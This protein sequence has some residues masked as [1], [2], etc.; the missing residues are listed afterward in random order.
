V[1]NLDAAHATLSDSGVNF[2]SPP[3]PIGLLKACVA[4]DPEG[5]WLEFVELLN[6]RS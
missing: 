6:P 5:N 4:R 2:G 3:V 1:D